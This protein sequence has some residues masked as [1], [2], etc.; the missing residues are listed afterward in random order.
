M[1]KIEKR[2]NAILE[3]LFSKG[4]VTVDRLTQKLNVSRVTI[5][6]DLEVL[7]TIGLLIRTKGGALTK[8]ERGDISPLIIRGN[9]NHLE[10][11]RIGRYAASLINDGDIVGMD[12]G[13]T[14]LEISK[15]IVPNKKFTLITN[16]LSIIFNISNNLNINTIIPGGV[17]DQ[18]EQTLVGDIAM[19]SLQSLFLDK[20]FLGISGIDKNRGITDNNAELIQIKQCLILNSKKVIIVSDSSKIGRINLI[21]VCQLKNIHSLITDKKP[22]DDFIRAMKSGKVIIEVVNEDGTVNRYD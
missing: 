9:E 4:E 8:I 2:K 5:C 16:N 13:S 21:L 3:E 18:R 6:R 11:Q 12:T 1:N 7:E 20:L 19:R 15:F 14:I 22:N 10:K 17:I